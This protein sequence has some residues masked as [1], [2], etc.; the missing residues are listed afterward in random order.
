MFAIDSAS[1]KL[2]TLEIGWTEKKHAVSI[3][4]SAFDPVWREV[5]AP[6]GASVCLNNIEFDLM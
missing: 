2:S 1:G 3:S 6:N 4:N 5:Q